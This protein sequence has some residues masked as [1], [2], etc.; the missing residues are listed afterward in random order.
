M[1]ILEYFVY[2]I[3]FLV[4]NVRYQCDRKLQYVRSKPGLFHSNLVCVLFQRLLD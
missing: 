2:L 1:K 3:F 4:T